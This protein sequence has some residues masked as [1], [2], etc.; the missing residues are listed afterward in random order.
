[1][2]SWLFKNKGFGPIGLDI[3][4]DSVKMIQLLEQEDQISVHAANKVRIDLG[5]DS[6]PDKRQ[7]LVVSAIERLFDSG[8]YHGRDVIT[9]VPSDKLKITSMRI[10]ESD[11]SDIEEIVRNEAAERFGL[12]SSKDS[13]NHILV[14][15]VKHDDAIKNE[16]ILF[17]ADNKTITDHISML[18]QAQLNPIAI[19]TVPA[20]LFRNFRRLLRRHGDKEQT[21]IFIDI[22]SLFAMVVFGWGEDINFVKKIPIGVAQIDRMLADKLDVD[23]Q[24]AQILRK[25]IGQFPKDSSRRD[26]AGEDS[27]SLKECSPEQV[28][29][30]RSIRQTIVD[31]VGEVARELTSEILLCLKYYTV[32]FRG[33]RI[34]KAFLSGGGAY[35][36]ILLNILRRQLAVDV[37]LAEPMRGFNLTA[38]E[39]IDFESDRRG[40][41]CEWAVA[42]GL[43]LKGWQPAEGKGKAYERN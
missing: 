7:Q 1:M 34:Q 18:E 16:L 4:N 25:N 5:D 19:D 6:D 26:V 22:G 39:G 12:D 40:P 33:K 29:L 13:I 21:F 17:A 42:V 36:K 8:N 23:F 9:S 20:A 14:G 3:G 24:Q 2:I 41:L 27:G 15:N 35:E 37:Q 10:S 38:S 30:D 11:S 28:I 43:A 31:T 32:T